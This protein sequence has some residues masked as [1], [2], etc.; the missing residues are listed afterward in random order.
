MIATNKL[1]MQGQA[2]QNREKGRS[3]KPNGRGSPGKPWTR[4]TRDR[5]MRV[6]ALDTFV[7]GASYPTIKC[8]LFS[9]VSR[10]NDCSW[11][12]LLLF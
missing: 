1:D 6:L 5:K 4:V 3:R 7:I 9:Q 11:P 2:V 10:P 12:I 8:A